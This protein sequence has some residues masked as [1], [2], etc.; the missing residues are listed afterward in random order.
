MV[1]W[2][3]L[4]KMIT[5]PGFLLILGILTLLFIGMLLAD[6]YGNSWDELKNA[7]YGRLSLEAYRGRRV[8]WDLY[9]PDVYK[10]PSFLML[11]VG[12]S[13]L[14]SKFF[15]AWD[16]TTARHFIV[17]LTF[18]LAVMAIYVLGRSLA[19]KRVG[20][21]AAL[22][23][24]SQPLLF[25]HAFINQKDV[26]FMAF[27]LTSVAIGVAAID[28]LRRYS[29]GLPPQKL[30][31]PLWD[32]RSLS[33][34]SDEWQNVNDGDKRTVII[35]LSIFA[36]VF[37]GFLLA[38][39]IT[40]WLVTLAYFGRAP[41]F[42]NEW[43]AQVA[44][45]AHQIAV[46]AYLRKVSLLVFRYGGTVVMGV[47]LLVTL[48]L[49]LV[50]KRHIRRVW[51]TYGVPV[52]KLWFE[53]RFIFLI[54]TSSVI[55]GIASAIRPL[56]ISA[57][58]IVMS[59]LLLEKKTRAITPLLLFVG[60]MSLTMYLSWPY[61]WQEPVYH[62][63]RSLVTSYQFPW[64]GPILFMGELYWNGPIPPT[65]LTSY[66]IQTPWYYLLVLIG[67]QL[68]EPMLLFAVLGIAVGC[69]TN[70]RSPRDLLGLAILGLWFLAPIATSI[71]SES[72]VYDNFR[73]FLF[74]LPPLFIMAGISLDFSLQYLQTG[75]L[76]VA[77]VA[78]VL[79][80]GIIGISLLHPYEYIYYNSL[81]GGVRGAY[82]RYELDYWCTS[83]DD[84]VTYVNRTMPKE[85]EVAVWG[86]GS[87][88]RRSIR[89]DIEVT[90]IIKPRGLVETSAQAAILCGRNYAEVTLFPE[91]EV[92]Y[93]VTINSLP[94]T[95]VK[96]LEGGQ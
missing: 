75:Y 15:P 3:K 56:G 95:V 87:V 29:T 45:Q 44:Q 12:G 59:Y 2:R 94:L 77:L 47:L 80:P 92:V 8:S 16:V 60:G 53:S 42:L 58:L 31:L 48:V 35:C 32:R 23:F 81:V 57:A 73:H 85:S 21:L 69:Y 17:F 91:S 76:R 82:G 88:V 72:V 63:W 61:L 83:L 96:D 24:A 79:V 28:R 26:P 11:W 9:E 7:E 84:A 20:I 43:F 27:Y 54:F 22:L 41:L 78:L 30:P 25:G 89:P 5:S 37:V 90:V 46:D 65:G 10:G 38:F 52:T 39:P 6:D 1:W 62:F 18:L 40:R 49:G 86:P 71:I 67:I 51:N 64:S 50:L 68:T 4:G 36:I 13:D 70:R 55:A 14:L 33:A 74:I 19:S 66:V 93:D 34:F